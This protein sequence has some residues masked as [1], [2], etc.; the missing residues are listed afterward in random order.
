MDITGLHLLITYKCTFECD[1]CFV[2]GSPFQNGTMTLDNIRHILAEAQSVGTIK[3]IYFEG[4]EPT[5]YY[6]LLIQAVKDAYNMGF[7]VGIVTNSYWATSISDAK[8]WLSPLASLVSDL[9]IS[10]DLFHYDEMIS[11]QAK[12]TSAAAE[13]L[14]I[15]LGMISIAK[16]ST[17]QD[18]YSIGMIEQ[19]ES[20]IMY[21]GRA[22]EKLVKDAQLQT[23]DTF[24]ECPYE[25][26]R[27]PGRLHV[28]PFGHLHICQGISIGNIFKDK[29]AHIF[30][31]YTPDSH[32]I[33]GP[34]LRGGP[35]NLVKKYQVPH[36]NEYADA[37]QLCYKTREQLRNLYPN[38]LTPDQ[39]Y[40]VML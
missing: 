17:S 12:N 30:E 13:E 38:I 7:K 28:D 27:D 4:G 10:S 35:V 24:T 6:P 9:S 5:L 18:T 19:G 21:R 22:A 31:S 33:A 2:W 36:S 26:F 40:G 23:W 8:L 34:L 15:P 11:E 20:D 3:W 39:V 25:D 16:P 1:H 14:G 37:C 32:P 29:L